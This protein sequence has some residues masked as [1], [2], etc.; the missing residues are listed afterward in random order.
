MTKVLLGGDPVFLYQR[1]IPQI[2]ER[3][4]DVDAHCISTSGFSYWFA[5]TAP[6]IRP[7]TVVT[8]DEYGAGR[9]SESENA[10]RLRY[11]REN[12][13]TEYWYITAFK[14]DTQ[15][16]DQINLLGCTVRV[17]NVEGKDVETFYPYV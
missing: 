9:G 16:F 11:I 7:V 6:E 5:R 1:K 8:P 17:M 12:G 14:A 15:I 2:V 3:L 4:G 13:I 10:M